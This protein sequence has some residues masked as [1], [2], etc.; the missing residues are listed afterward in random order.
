MFEKRETANTIAVKREVPAIQKGEERKAAYAL[1]LCTV[2]V[3][4]IIEYNDLAIM[5]QEYDNILNNLNL[6]NFPKDE[7]LLK[8]LKQLLDVISFFRIQDGEKKLLEEQYKKKVKDAIWSAIPSPSVILAGGKAGVAGLVT[9]AVLA[10]GTGYMNYRKERATIDDEKKQ[11][12]WELQKSAMEQFHALRRE[13]FDTAWR[14]ADAYKFE[15]AYRLTER[16]ISQYNMILTD[17]DSIRRYERLAYIQKKFEAY[18]PFWYQ[19]GHAAAEICYDAQKI[20]LDEKQPKDIRNTYKDIYDEYKT[21]ACDAFDEFLDLTNDKN[22]KMNNLLRE[23]QTRA[24]C[25][26]EKFALIAE[27]AIPMSEKKELLEAAAKNSGNAFDT[28]QLCAS[29]YLQIGETEKAIELLRMLVNEDYNPEMN[30]QLLSMLY[31]SSI[32]KMRDHYRNDHETL[33][34]RDLREYMFPWPENNL[35]EAGAMVH[36]CAFVENQNRYLF[37]QYKSIVSD[38]IVKSANAFDDIVQRPGDITGALIEFLNG[39][40]KDVRTLFGNNDFSEDI[41]NKIAEGILAVQKDRDDILTDI[42]LR[43]VDQQKDSFSFKTVSKKAVEK[44]AE[45]IRQQAI[46]VN[47]EPNDKKQLQKLANYMNN[48]FLFKSQ[49]K[50]LGGLAIN[51]GAEVEKTGFERLELIGKNNQVDQRFKEIVKKYKENGKLIKGSDANLII[52]NFLESEHVRCKDDIRKMGE[53]KVVAYLDVHWDTDLLFT[54]EGVGAYECYSDNSFAAYYLGH[55]KT[56]FEKY[57]SG[58][59]RLID[60]KRLKIEKVK[61]HHKHVDM[62]ALIQMIEELCN[63]VPRNVEK[64]TSFQDLVGEYPI[65]PIIRYESTKKC[66]NYIDAADIYNKCPGI[67]CQECGYESCMEFSENVAQNKITLDYC[68]YFSEEAKIDLEK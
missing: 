32:K 64:T 31:V 16:Q 35:D 65:A 54:T 24:A 22:Q 43:R 9:S 29:S 30:A 63:N 19:L 6:Q 62:N 68:P 12:D 67:N 51:Q 46:S 38:Y 4:Q 36:T 3:S 23:D 45:K 41:C 52:D 50:L 33:C 25:A 2:S 40:N 10:V 14:L 34:R 8:I 58:R 5:E 26:L 7:A 57:N 48:L 15:D 37:E 1:N 27:D 66:F 49:T 21:K 55:D 18:P 61:F 53:D 56:G 11:K 59:I 42:R 44:M 60:E 47:N 28:L 17:P 13:L 20:Y 39:I